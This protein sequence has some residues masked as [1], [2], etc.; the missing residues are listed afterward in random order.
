MHEGPK[1]RLLSLFILRERERTRAWESH[2]REQ[3]SLQKIIH[4]SYS[5]SCV[6]ERETGRARVRAQRERVNVRESILLIVV[7]ACGGQT[8]RVCA[9]RSRGPKVFE[10]EYKYKKK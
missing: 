5:Y 3:Q 7:V 6:T 9:R 10:F 1:E 8:K 4:F 2:R